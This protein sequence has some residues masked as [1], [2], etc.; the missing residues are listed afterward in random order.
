LYVV[1]I[2]N[3]ALAIIMAVINVIPFVSL[4]TPK[5]PT[6]FLSFLRCHSV[7]GGSITQEECDRC[8]MAFPGFKSSCEAATIKSTGRR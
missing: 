4:P 5:I 6:D 2:L 3:H 7:P 8:L 1:T